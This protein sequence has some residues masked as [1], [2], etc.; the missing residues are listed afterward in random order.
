MK[1]N[2]FLVCLLFLCSC[3]VDSNSSQG[4]NQDMTKKIDN[5]KCENLTNAAGFE[6]DSGQY[7]DCVNTF[8][9]SLKAGCGSKYG[10]NIYRWMAGAYIELDKLDSAKIVINDGLKILPNDRGV[11]GVA[12]RLARKQN[13]TDNQLFFLKKK[14]NI[15]SSIQEIID[16][17]SSE[18]LQEDIVKLEVALE[19]KEPNGQWNEDISDRIIEFTRSRASTFSQLSDYY[20]NKAEIENEDFYY[21]NQIDYLEEWL[22]VD[23]SNA[24]DIIKKLRIA[25]KNAGRDAI[26]IDQRRWEQNESDANVALVYINELMDISDY[27]KAIEV[28]LTVLDD[29]SENIKI[30]EKLS[31]AY[32]EVYNQDEAVIAYEKLIRLNPNEIK[33]QTKISE[34][35]RETG[36]YEKAIEFANKIVRTKPSA[37]AFYNRAMIYIALA[38]YCKGDQLTMSDKAVYEMAWQDLNTASSKGDKKAKK[39][40]K[41]YSKNNLIT[42][43]EDWFKLSGK[44]NTF[45]PKGKC[46]S[47]IKKSIRKRDF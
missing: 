13:D 42:Q 24:N 33:Y 6:Y 5:K 46:Y 34:I 28:C 3:A 40:A 7:Q 21:S 15:E 26:E 47:V 25:Y 39:Q 10:E 12:A 20:E 31:I 37:N 1:F 44:P 45:R 41:F 30:L 36:D 17:T 38:D 27:D 23:P 11:I 19:I 9:R 22:S 8:S 4:Y 16:N 2:S 32:T 14:Y 29:D 35:Y 43:F 18:D